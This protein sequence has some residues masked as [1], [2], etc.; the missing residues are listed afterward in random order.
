[1]DI[2]L[3]PEWDVGPPGGPRI[4]ASALLVLLAGVQD[5]GSLA[6]AARGAGQSYRHAWGLVKRAEALF[7]AP[8]IE[9]GR[10]RGSA[11]TDLARKLIWADRRIAA[12][13]SP[14]LESLASELERDLERSLEPN[15]AVVRIDASHGFAVARLMELTHAA[16]LPVELHYRSSLE[17]VASLAR[18]DCDLAGLHVPIGEFEARA[19]RRYLRW[20]RPDTHCL[21]HVALRTQGLFVARGNPKNVGGLAD[22]RRTDLRFVNRPEGSGTRVLT[23]LLLEREGIAE[24]EVLGFDDTE[25]THAAVAAYIASGMADIGIGVQT[26]AQRFGLDFIPLLRERYF[27]ALRIASLD[28]PH[29]QPV[30]ALLASPASRAAIASLVGYHAAE[31]GR[32]QRLDEAFDPALLP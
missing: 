30:L 11:L 12:R 20:L 15:R 26:A 14:L 22:L 21:V 8:L 23:E 18:G 25:L 16:A 4:D 13:L 24:G 17:S 32:V 9:S 3:R 6:D 7:G 31:T 10:G 2:R 5:G 27:F 1:M 29:V 28:Q 19:L